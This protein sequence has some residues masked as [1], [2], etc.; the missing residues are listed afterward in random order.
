M[1]EPDKRMET[2]LTG[3]HECT[4]AAQMAAT[5]QNSLKVALRI[6]MKEA[7]KCLDAEAIARQSKAVTAKVKSDLGYRRYQLSAL[8]SSSP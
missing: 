4:E 3:S 7:L 6:R 2:V 5:I 1:P 8:S